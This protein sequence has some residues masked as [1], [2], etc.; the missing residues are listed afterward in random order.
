MLGA[1]S[2]PCNHATASGPLRC[3]RKT[4]SPRT[5]YILS[6][7]GSRAVDTTI[8]G[9]PAGITVLSHSKHLLSFPNTQIW[10]DWRLGTRLNLIAPDS[11]TLVICD[12]DKFNKMLLAELRRFVPFDANGVANLQLKHQDW[13]DLFINQVGN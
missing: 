13:Q 3:I 6:R 5:Y 1:P 10:S 12:C 9:I 11:D 8:K 4:S 2:H 7:A